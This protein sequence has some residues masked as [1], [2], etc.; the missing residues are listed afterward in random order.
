MNDVLCGP[1][2]IYEQIFIHVS[3]LFY[4]RVHSIYTDSI[5]DIIVTEVLIHATSTRFVHRSMTV[6]F[7][8][9][10]IY[11]VFVLC[12]GCC[13]KVLVCVV[14][15]EFASTPLDFVRS[16]GIIPADQCPGGHKTDSCPHF[17]GI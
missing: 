17:R 16:I 11:V 13:L 14:G 3:L 6:M 1:T 4:K 8:S 5:F 12:R 2:L 9:R 15:P 7:W 10:L